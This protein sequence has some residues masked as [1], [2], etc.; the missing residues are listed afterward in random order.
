MD[1]HIG[2][3]PSRDVLRRSTVVA[4][5]FRDGEYPPRVAEHCLPTGIAV[6]HRGPWAEQEFEETAG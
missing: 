1:F 2:R 5:T 4:S 6:R 3:Q